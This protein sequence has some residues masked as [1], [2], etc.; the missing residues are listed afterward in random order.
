MKKEVYIW[1]DG[2]CLGNGRACTYG[3]YAAILECGAHRLE[4]SGHVKSSEKPTNNKMELRAVIEGVK[5]LK[6][7]G[8]E[9]VVYADSN[10]VCEGVKSIREWMKNGWRT[11]AK[12][13]VKNRD[14]WE[15]LISVTKASGCHF[16]FEHVDGHADCTNNNLCDQIA[17]GEAKRSKIESC[18][19]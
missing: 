11:T 15:E 10:Y 17:K 8:Y 7:P 2:S 18:A 13:E 9:V 14:L 3:G 5:A 12:T 4:V 16:R 1:T 6:K 19:I